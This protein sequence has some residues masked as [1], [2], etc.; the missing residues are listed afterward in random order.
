MFHAG[1]VQ[2]VT[3]SHT[4][5]CIYLSI[6]DI[7]E[8]REATIRTS[9]RPSW[10]SWTPPFPASVRLGLAQ[11]GEPPGIL[12]QACGV[13]FNAP[14]ARWSSWSGGPPRAGD[15]GR[16]APG[17]AAMQAPGCPAAADGREHLPATSCRAGW[18]PRLQGAP[19]RVTVKAGDSRE[20]EAPLAE[21][22]VDLASRSLLEARALLAR[23]VAEDR[24]V[25]A[26]PRG[27]PA[28][29]RN[30]RPKD[31]R[32]SFLGRS[33]ARGPA[34]RA[35]RGPGWTPRGTW[36]WPASWAHCAVRREFRPV[37]GGILPSG[38]WRHAG[39]GRPTVPWT[40]S[41]PPD[42]ISSSRKQWSLPPLARASRSSQQENHAQKRPRVPG[43]RN[44]S[45]RNS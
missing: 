42:L 32:A 24:L 23:P 22:A 16:A 30:C 1:P 43:P 41:R 25:L 26:V 15:P 40:A 28:S 4:D 39:P 13:L 9:A 38:R 37:W 27:H 12:E 7:L 31:L 10:P 8:I 5:N 20:A 44:R 6:S 21:G 36:P 17:R 2:L 11:S 18:P 33:P 45:T 34:R 14:A 29:S 19:V 35:L 3:R